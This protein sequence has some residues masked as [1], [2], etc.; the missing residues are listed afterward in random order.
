MCQQ[1]H[2]KERKTKKG[3]AIKGLPLR[4]TGVHSLGELSEESWRIGVSR[5][6]LLR[7][8]P[9]HWLFF[10]FYK[11]LLAHSQAHSLNWI[12]ATETTVWPA[13]L[14]MFTIWILRGKVADSWCRTSGRK[15]GKYL[16]LSLVQGCPGVI[17]SLALPRGPS[18]S[19]SESPMAPEKPQ[20]EKHG[21]LMVK[22][23]SC[24][25][26]AVGE[27]GDGSET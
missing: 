7:S 18:S 20:A 2:R 15:G 8:N 6:Q 27:L 25:P 10:F 19:L 3:V 21:G 9:T 16:S 1:H 17:R 14:K 12:V 22:T 11:V 23:R 4:A 5:P 13:K 26:T 24:P